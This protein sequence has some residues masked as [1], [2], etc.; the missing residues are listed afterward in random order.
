MFIDKAGCVKIADF[1]LSV[2]SEGHS[3][4]YYSMRSGNVRWTAPELIFPELYGNTATGITPRAPVD[5]VVQTA[6]PTKESDVYAFACLCVEV[7]SKY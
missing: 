6:R 7:S 3:G 1:G 2:L 5:G 4:N